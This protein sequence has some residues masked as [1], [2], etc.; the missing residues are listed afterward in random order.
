MSNPIVEVNQ[1]RVDR[2]GRVWRVKA[3]ARREVELELVDGPREH[4]VRS[5]IWVGLWTVLRMPVA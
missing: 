3:M 1:H 2:T 4:M 5:A